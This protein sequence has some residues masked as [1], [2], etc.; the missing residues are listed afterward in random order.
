VYSFWKGCFHSSA[1]AQIFVSGSVADSPK[2][3]QSMMPRA[4]GFQLAESG[5]DGDQVCM[6]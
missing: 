5:S 3:W 1:I 4:G 2:W 6:H